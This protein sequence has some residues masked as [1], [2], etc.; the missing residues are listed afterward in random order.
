LTADAR[1]SPA[2][3]AKGPAV[4][5]ALERMA[6]LTNALGGII[7]ECAVCARKTSPVEAFSKVATDACVRCAKAIEA[8]ARRPS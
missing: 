4:Y 6:D 8:L 2:G 3:G 1:R 7:R 5:D